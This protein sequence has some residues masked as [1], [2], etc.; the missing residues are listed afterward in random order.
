MRHYL[1]TVLV[2]GLRDYCIPPQL[3][4]GIEDC[5][6]EWGDEMPGANRGGS[7][8][9]TDKNNR[10]EGYGRGTGRGIFC[11]RCSAWRGQLGLEP[12]PDCFAWAKGEPPCSAC[13]VC[14]LVAVFREIHQVLRDDGTVWLNLGDSY[15]TGGGKVGEH[16]GGPGQGD[17][18]KEMNPGLSGY[19]HRPMKQVPDQKNPNAGIPTYQPNRRPIPGLKPKDLCGIPWRVVFALQ[20][21]GWWLRSDII[22][23]KP[24]PMPESV[25]DRPTKAHEYL[26]LLSKSERY[27]FDQEAVKESTLPTLAKMPDGWATHEGSHGSFHRD[28][29]ES[30]RPDNVIVS[31]R[32]LRSVW[33][34]ST[35]PYPEAHFATFP[36][37]LVEPC[38]KAGTS[39]KGGCRACGA[40]WERVVKRTVQGYQDQLNAHPPSTLGWRPTCCCRGQRGETVPAFILD[41][42]AGTATVGVVALRLGRRFLGIELS[43][44]YVELAKNRIVGDAPLFNATTEE[45]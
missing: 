3:W 41:P 12:L 1:P 39:E 30:G 2:R 26:F 25:T 33:T 7:G 9:P 10:G 38:I 35:E 43:P 28:G 44:T 19:R 40:P 22:W 13:Y 27:F 18:W 20:A 11:L 24:N 21:D 4:G 34:I 16:P 15:A 31:R 37:A 17:R 29:R 32:N 36:K 42:F 8:T 5:E 45:A 14:H 6:H 23:A